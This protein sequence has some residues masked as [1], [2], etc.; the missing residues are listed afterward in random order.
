MGWRDRVLYPYSTRLDREGIY[1][2]AAFAFAEMLLHGATTCVDF[3]YLQ[4]EGNDNAEAVIQAARDTGHP[5]GAR[6][7]DVRLGRARPPRYRET[8]RGRG[9]PR[10]RADPTRM[11]AIRRSA[12][13]PRRT[14]RTAPRP[15]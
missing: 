6:A 5:P 7:H 8:P 1:L 2:G 10:A 15:R 13:S 9:A 3:F 12:C 11:P 4:D 14:A